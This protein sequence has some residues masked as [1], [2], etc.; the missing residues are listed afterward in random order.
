MS[1]QAVRARLRELLS[2]M[3]Q[4]RDSGDSPVA[5]EQV[6]PRHARA[7]R[8]W[9]LMF[10]TW[11]VPVWFLTLTG[12][13]LW[14]QQ[15]T[16]WAAPATATAQAAQAASGDAAAASRQTE[17]VMTHTLDAV[18]RDQWADARSALASA[19]EVLAQ[20]PGAADVPRA[21]LTA[22]MDRISAALDAEET[23]LHDFL[24]LN[25]RLEQAVVAV[26]ES[27][28][29]WQAAHAEEEIALVQTVA[30]GN[31]RSGEATPTTVVQTPTVPSGGRSCTTAGSGATTA[32]AAAIGE[33]INSYR[34]SRGLETLNVEE[35]DTLGSHTLTMAAA[36]GIWHSG[37]DNVVGCVSNAS[38]DSLV[39]AWSRSAPHNEQM[40]RTDV[41]VLW[42]GGAVREG[43]LYGAAA[44]G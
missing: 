17:L 22:A 1:P 16:L 9:E 35:S 6:S 14:W 12:G 5:Q 36:G 10:W 43:W 26:G 31:V 28:A 37:A 27:Q 41:T 23:S 30:T 18:R 2:Q 34:S 40:L 11:F 19:Q 24:Q 8:R 38:A 7:Q 4:Q 13:G 15:G 42:V 29:Q 3:P 25:S 39:V 21:Q 44:F 32:Q 20:S 33:A